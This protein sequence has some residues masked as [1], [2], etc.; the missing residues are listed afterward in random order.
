VRQSAGLNSVFPRGESIT[1]SECASISHPQ[2]GPAPL[3]KCGLNIRQGAQRAVL[4]P[5][6]QGNLA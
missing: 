4:A 2:S 6:R 5:A 3:S 1:E